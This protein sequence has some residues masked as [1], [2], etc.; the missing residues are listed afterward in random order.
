MNVLLM[1]ADAQGTFDWL[2]PFAAFPE[3]NSNPRDVVYRLLAAF[4]MGFVVAGVYCFTT[5][6]GEKA[7]RSF[8]ATLVLL[9]VLIGLVTLV[10]GNNAAR[11]FSLVGA[12]A[13]VRFRTVVEDIR[14]TAFVIFGVAAGMAAG[15]GYLLAPLA[16]TPLVFLGSILFRRQESTSSASWG[17][18]VLRLSTGRPVVDDV[19]AVLK[20]HL[21]DFRLAGLATARGG[22]AL[23]LTFAV[24]L[25]GPD[26]VF[27][28]V[29]AL[30]RVEGVQSVEVR[31]K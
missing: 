11:A 9:S 31:D 20:Q 1:T 17:S 29:N 21:K 19:Q 13:I 3:E 16:C 25:P 10:V 6:R 22:S 5:P 27:A 24:R 23:D 7:N 8:L 15:S 28:L 30:N 4:I 26:Q 18:V 12:L 2:H 14:D